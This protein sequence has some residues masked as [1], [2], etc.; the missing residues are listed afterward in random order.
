MW[1]WALPSGAI[2]LVCMSLPMYV[3][4]GFNF[5]STGNVMSKEKFYLFFFIKTNLIQ[6]IIKAL[7]KKI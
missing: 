2:T 5:L 3:G 1:Y 6:N 7:G 4:G